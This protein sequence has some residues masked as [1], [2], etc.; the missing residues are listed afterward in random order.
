MNLWNLSVC[1]LKRKKGKTL[2]LFVVFVTIGAC[3]I[4]LMGIRHSLEQTIIQKQERMIYMTASGDGLWPKEAHKALKDSGL[5]KSMEASVSA[6]VKTKWKLI[7]FIQDMVGENDQLTLAGYEETASLTAFR[8][9]QLLLKEGRHLT[10]DDR[11]QAL[12]HEKLAEKNGLKVGQTITLG[13]K[14]ATIAGIFTEGKGG[15]NRLVNINLANTVIADEALV[16]AISGKNGY[17]SI[18]AAVN[19]AKT[20]KP[21]INSI[22]QWP[23]PWESLRVQNAEEY[24]GD[25]Y[26][27][28]IT[29]YALVNRI[30]TMFSVLSTI[31]LILMLT[32]WINNRVK[33][34]GILLSVGMSKRKVI[35]HYLIEVLIVAVIAFAFSIAAGVFAGQRLGDAL[36]SQVN[37]GITAR[38][39]QGGSLVASRIDAV[40]VSIG[41]MDVLGLYAQGMLTCLV[42][43]AA[44][45]YSIARLQPK[46]ILSRMS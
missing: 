22:K 42:A 41:L 34:T 45:S 35:A 40:P 14:T 31:V 18:V 27:N 3:L 38:A 33:E 5:V 8:E 7:D 13:D 2:T 12:V 39:L 1:Y 24:Y 15:R 25:A 37:G 28:V 17:H 36:M 21:I 30:L 43:V 9:K 32:F 46:Q 20:V 44:S 6:T 29:L 16:S 11:N 19:D 4:S 23:L 26:Q 10:K